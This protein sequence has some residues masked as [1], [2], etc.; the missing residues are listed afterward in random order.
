MAS[1]RPNVLI[2]T[3]D[4][5]RPDHVSLTGYRG[6]TTRT[7]D[8]LA[9][10]GVFFVNA[11]CQAPNTWIS[12]ASLF[13]GCN[14][15]SHGVRTPLSKLSE[16][17]P[18]MA[19]VFQAA[20]YSTFG[21][22]AMSLLSEKAGFSRGFQEYVL[23]GLQSEEGVLSHRY[24]R[25]A[26]D[27]LTI[28]RRWLQRCRRPFFGWVHYFGTHKLENALLDLPERYRREYSEYAQYYD[29]KIAFADEQFLAPLVSELEALGVLDETVFIVWSDHGEDLHDV[30][31]GPRWGHHWDL[32][33][34]LMRTLL[35]VRAP[36]ALPA[37][38]RR[39]DIAQSIDILPTLM[40]IVGLPPAA[41][42]LEGRSL[43][44]P[45]APT[46]PIVYM[47][48]L[49]QGFVAVREGRFKLIIEE[50]GPSNLGEQKV[51]SKHLSWRLRLLK[52]T[53]RKLLPSRRRRSKKSQAPD[54]WQRTKGQP[55]EVLERLL[56]VGR[57]SLYD[58]TNDPAEDQD[59]AAQHPD[60][61]ARL[62]GSIRTGA[63]GTVATRKAYST[64]EEEAEIK[65]RLKA[66]GYL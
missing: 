65:D 21:L 28:T 17:V 16:H 32:K 52:D 43:V 57:C 40:D 4:C 63:E 6:S 5:V 45:Q 25:S 10:E 55:E 64:S 26:D 46:E 61:V 41:D 51:L 36:W 50:R 49:C 24:Y 27:T 53:T 12:H 15:Y 47:E 18:T 54:S 7:L 35:V 29:G 42:H 62:K 39:H 44:D 9:R 1:T 30:E 33:E 19:E 11:Y 3:L 56:D 59:I 31:H 8:S 48:N 34:S 20:D 58:L 14:P 66:L 23:D 38:A 2:I 22:P 13:T 37:G 60:Q